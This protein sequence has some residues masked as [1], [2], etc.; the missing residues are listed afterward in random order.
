M[1]L[2]S[3]GYLENA[4][5]VVCSGISLGTDPQRP[6]QHPENLRAAQGS[7]KG[8][9]AIRALKIIP[10]RIESLCHL[11]Q[12]GVLS[13]DLPQDVSPEKYLRMCRPP[14]TAEVLRH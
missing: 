10:P 14:K 13:Q 1:G 7:R 5:V 12:A 6:K 3:F 11:T 8:G 4:R 2:G 9:L